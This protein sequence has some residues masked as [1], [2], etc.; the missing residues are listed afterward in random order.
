MEHKLVE[1]KVSKWGRLR[2]GKMVEKKD[3]PWEKHSV[4]T[5]GQ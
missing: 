3:L 5:L 4:E 2:A 1:L